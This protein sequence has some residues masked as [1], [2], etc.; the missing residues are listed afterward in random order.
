MNIQTPFAFIGGLIKQVAGY[1]VSQK[2]GD[3]IFEERS[4]SPEVVHE[5]MPAPKQPESGNK[6]LSIP[7]ELP[8]S[9]DYSST[10]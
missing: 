3:V 5:I 1:W 4:I 9:G 7:L 10:Y 8:G 2:T 6:Q